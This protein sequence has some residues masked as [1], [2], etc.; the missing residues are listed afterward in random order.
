ME[1]I[2]LRHAYASDGS[3]RALGR[4]RDRFEK[5]ERPHFDAIIYAYSAS[6]M[7]TAKHFEG[8]LSRLPY[9]RVLGE[10]EFPPHRYRLEEEYLILGESSL[11]RYY[12]RPDPVPR[13]LADYARRALE[14]VGREL[15]FFHTARALIISHAPLVQQMTY[16]LFPERPILTNVLLSGCQ[17]F[18]FQYF[19]RGHAANLDF[20]TW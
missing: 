20:L 10:L 1:I 5:L 12:L 3:V 19:P 4:A 7:E 15:F 6:A 14:A 2:M 9:M 16:E 13:I 18:R 8:F 11:T 17:G